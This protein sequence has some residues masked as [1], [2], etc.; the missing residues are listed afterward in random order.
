[1]KRLLF[2]LLIP[3]TA[4]APWTRVTGPYEGPAHHFSVVIPDGWMK[5]D[6]DSYLLISR[7]GPFLQ[8]ILL[9]SRNLTDP[10]SH[11]RRTMNVAMLPQEAAEVILDDL[12]LDR[13]VR[14]LQVLENAPAGI[15]HQDGFKILFTYKN[16]DGLTLKTLFYGFIKGR[17]FYSIRYTAAERYYFAKDVGTFKK[18]LAGFRLLE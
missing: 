16:G 14:N 1:M 8:Y 13:S 6:S 3:I 2:I 4:C 15:A 7:D 12:G 18:V 5:F 10:F 17:L 9:E 11:T